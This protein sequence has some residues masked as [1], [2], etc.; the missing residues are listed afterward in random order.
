MRR[1]SRLIGIIAATL[2]AVHA[3]FAADGSPRPLRDWKSHPAILVLPAASNLYAIGDVHGDI[4]KVEQLLV[5]AHLLNSIPATPDAAQ[6]SAGTATLIC[7]GDMIDKYPHGLEVI[8][9]FRA[10]QQSAAAAGGQVIITMGNHEA[11]FLAAAGENKK[12]AN[13]SAELQTAKLDPAQV[14]AATDPRGI[15]R[16][17]NDL[18]IAAKIGDWF[19]CHA[20]NTHLLTIDQLNTQ[21]SHGVDQDGFGTAIL[22]EPN[23]I[24]EARMHPVPW[25]LSEDAPQEKKTTGLGTLPAILTA[26]GVK[27]L[28]VGHQPGKVSFGHHVDRPADTPFAFE[29][30]LFLID[31]GMSRGVDDGRGVVLKISCGDKTKQS[32]TAV[33]SIDAA[34]NS[35]GLWSDQQSDGIPKESRTK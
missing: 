1:A 12:A 32:P 35:S 20:G 5:A 8:A 4:D 31:C 28:V 10:L 11:E 33:T 14:A 25:W 2:C 15:G 26:L 7:T 3:A 27:H 30:L 23:S 22:S 13:F 24:L 29:G 6:W 17:L 21:I 9:L 34:G 18:P 19:F 16:W